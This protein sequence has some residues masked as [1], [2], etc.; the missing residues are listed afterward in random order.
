V[1][2]LSTSDAQAWT[3]P[4]QATISALARLL[5]RRLNADLKRCTLCGLGEWVKSP[6]LSSSDYSIHWPRSAPRLTGVIFLILSEKQTSAGVVG[7]SQDTEG[8]W[9]SECDKEESPAHICGGA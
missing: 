1:W 3:G 7:L 6:A 2:R 9:S 8:G 5:F 4:K